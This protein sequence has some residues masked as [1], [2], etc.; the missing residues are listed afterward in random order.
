[1]K[2]TISIAGFTHS[3]K[4]K[5]IQLDWL[6][7]CKKLKQTVRTSETVAEYQRLA[8]DGKAGREARHKIKDIGGFVGGTLTS[9]RRKKSTVLNRSL[10]TLDMDNVDISAREVWERIVGRFPNTDMCLYSTHTHTPKLPRLR[11]I[12][13]LSREVT[14]A[15][16]I[17][18]SRKIAEMIDIELFDT[19]TYQ[20]ERFMFWPSTPKD[21]EFIYCKTKS[22]QHLDPDRILK[23]YTDWNDIGEWPISQNEHKILRTDIDKQADPT[24]K[25]GIIGAFCRIYGIE[26]AIDTFLS[27]VY[28]KSDQPDRY[29]YLAGSTYNGLAVYDN[30][31]A[32]SHHNT[33]PAGGM[34]CNS[35]D[36]VR[37]HKFGKLDSDVKDPSSVNTT[38][39]PSYKA[40]TDFCLKDKQVVK[41]SINEKLESATDLFA[42][43]LDG[44]AGN[45]DN[46]TN[47]TNTSDNLGSSKDGKGVNNGGQIEGLDVEILETDDD[48]WKGK[49]ELDKQNNALCTVNNIVLIL[50]NDKEF[51]DAFAVDLFSMRIVSRR[52][53]KWRVESKQIDTKGIDDSASFDY[54]VNVT[55]DYNKYVNDYDLTMIRWYLETFY[56]MPYNKQKVK[57][58]LQAVAYKNAYHPIKDFFNT[59]EWDGAERI[60]YL[61]HN[62]LGVENNAY[63]REVSK[64]FFTAAVKRVYQAGCKFDYIPVL[65]GFEGIKKSSLIRVL[66]TPFFSDSLNSMGDQKSYEQI[67]GSWV[68]ELGELTAVKRAEV[69]SVKHFVAKQTDKFRPAFGETV[70]DFPRTCVFFGT[71]NNDKFLKGE[72]GDRRFWPLLCGVVPARF[73]IKK[74]FTNEDRLQIWAEALHYYKQGQKVYLPKDLEAVARKI[75]KDFVEADE[76]QSA[77]E[78]FINTP[79]P[80]EWKEMNPLERSVWYKNLTTGGE[81]ISPAFETRDRICAME[82]AKELYDLEI[83]NCTPSILKGINTILNRLEYLEPYRGK[84]KWYGMQRGFKIKNI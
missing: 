21:G 27:D 9:G 13:P 24:E 40:M 71:S 81:G 62:Y 51:K 59:L 41:Q 19:T 42:D 29:T 52:P 76:R 3:T 6:T 28:E 74:Q 67:Q 66:S 47:K 60:P 14:P 37:L 70:Q 33:D 1:M 4:W 68:I 18:I 12:I 53:L 36:L 49:L 83:K 75:Q 32:F 45:K 34:T 44:A 31:F 48:D 73:D 63:T 15:E 64:I 58:G 39:L 54:L 79:L 82:V 20:P 72:N 57:D 22:S 26:E 10:V 35:F 80:F 46:K 69:E 16:Y 30:K 2:F 78:E 17:P 50:Q 61:F 43:L 65:V 7:L 5:A 38:K 23:L 56:K 25:Q 8:L 84:F 77:V 11:L 55:D